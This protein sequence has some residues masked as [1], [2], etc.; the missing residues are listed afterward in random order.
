MWN[1]L[2]ASLISSNLSTVA[3]IWDVHSLLAGQLSTFCQQQ[4][5]RL[6]RHATFVNDTKHEL[7]ELLSSYYITSRALDC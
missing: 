2:Q 4:Q 7:L 6:R 1:Y 3:A 5:G